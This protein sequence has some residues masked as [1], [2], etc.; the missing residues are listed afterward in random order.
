M[1]TFYSDLPPELLQSLPVL[2]IVWIFGACWGSFLNVC[3]IRI[4]R[5]MSVSHPRS[6]CFSCGK[7]VA[8]HDNLPVLSWFLLRGKCR[9]CG[10]AFSF[11]YPLVEALTATLFT[12]IWMQH[13]PSWVML[14]Y[15]LLA[16]GLLLGSGVDLDEF[17]IPDRVTWGGILIGV[18]L[19][20][21]LPALHG[22]ESALEGLT[23]GAIG[24]ATGFGILWAVGKIGTLLFR[25]EAMG[26]GDVKLMGA[27]GAFLGAPA[28]FFIL[29]VSALLGSVFGV[30]LILLGKNELGGRIPFGP[31]ISA[32]ALVWVFGG[33]VLMD[34]YLN[35]VL[36][37][38]QP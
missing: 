4:P 3:I 11:R 30:T 16:F 31:Y 7:P 20:A 36:G 29:F 10:A 35:L 8:W 26:F 37:P 33:D 27:L 28:V 5:E 6:H 24:A 15:W 38:P 2:A 25:K 9:H 19:S 12:G 1:I 13:G 14:A 22:K 34:A 23:A 21:L 17:W 32:A 18:P